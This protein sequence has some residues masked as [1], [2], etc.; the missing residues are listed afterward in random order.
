MWRM[1]TLILAFVIASIALRLLPY[2]LGAVV[3]GLAWIAVGVLAIVT[4]FTGE[5]KDRV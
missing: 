3:G 1:L 4:W 5:K 2:V